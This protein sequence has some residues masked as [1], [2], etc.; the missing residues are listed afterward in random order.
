[1]A[2]T[3]S[4]P[5]NFQ[6]WHTGNPMRDILAPAPPPP[7]PA[8]S[9]QRAPPRPGPGVQRQLEIKASKSPTGASRPPP[10]T[11]GGHPQ[12]AGHPGKPGGRI[13][14]KRLS[15]RHEDSHDTS[16]SGDPA[17]PGVVATQVTRTQGLEHFPSL[18]EH[19]LGRAAKST[20]KGWDI[21]SSNHAHEN[22]S[23]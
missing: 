6:S 21:S 19:T 5:R 3:I 17:G 13:K 7:P 22:S 16:G 23:T 12:K 2:L 8:R 1:M 20:S 4:R 11:P 9:V 15:C 18:A 10:P 14:N